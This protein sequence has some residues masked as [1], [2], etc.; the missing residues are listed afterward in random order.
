[1]HHEKD[2][3]KFGILNGISLVMLMIMQIG[4]KVSIEN[5]SA[6]SLLLTT[7]ATTWIIFTYYTSDLTARMT[8]GP[9][10]IPIKS[11]HDVKEQDFK[12]ITMSDTSGHMFLKLS[13][14][15]SAMN[16]FYYNNMHENDDA[17]IDTIEE[18][19]DILLNTKKVLYWS[20]AFE[21]AEDSRFK[22][23]IMED[24]VYANHVWAFQ[25]NSE[26]TEF[27]NFHLSKLKE[28]GM[29]DR[30]Y[31]T[32]MYRANKDFSTMADAI[33][34]GYENSVLPFLLFACGIITS[35][36]T[37]AFEQVKRKIK[38]LKNEQMYGSDIW[39]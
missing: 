11:F 3:E 23:L 39:T 24:S 34:I 26:F 6:K 1:M 28:S 7:C 2:S 22:A 37:V 30:L 5:F 35:I 29:R 31:S 10:D 9:A 14:P 21:L 32:W 20:S 25:K 36:V 15:G 19:I 12:V 18:V 27:F 17:Y 16:S 33:S 13:Q 4:Y 38:P 8:S